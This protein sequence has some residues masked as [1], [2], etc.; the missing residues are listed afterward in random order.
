MAELATLGDLTRQHHR[1]RALVEDLDY[2]IAKA[3]RQSSGAWPTRH[4]KAAIE[5]MTSSD[6]SV[7]AEQLAAFKAYVIEPSVLAQLPALKAVPLV[8]IPKETEH[9]AGTAYWAAENQPTPMTRLDFTSTQLEE[10]SL[11]AIVALSR[12]LLRLANDTARNAILRICRRTMTR[13]LDTALL[14][15][16]AASTA[17]PAGLLA[18]VVGLTGGSPDDLSVE[19]EELVATVS[20]GAP[21]TPV[22]V[23]SPRA[24]AYLARQ[25]GTAFKDVKLKGGEILGAPLLVSPGAANNLI[26]I[27]AHEIATHDGLMEIDAS[28][29]ASL[30]M[31]DTPTDGAAQL[32]PLWQTNTVATRLVHRVAWTKLSSD[33]VGY[34]TLDAIGGSPA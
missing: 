30:Q 11:N 17:Q 10:R 9:G 4:Q 5:A 14:G 33:S 28:D 24:V 15:S 21:T 7:L 27:D 29:E 1:Y 18:G 31:S 20:D 8:P 32:T 22:F 25:T 6:P 3:L 2:V 26:L 16:T 34:L 13:A 12:T 23:T 19:L